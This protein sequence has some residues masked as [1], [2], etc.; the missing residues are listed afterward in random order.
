MIEYPQL[1]FEITDNAMAVLNER[2]LLRDDEGEIVEEPQDIFK[3]VAEKIASKEK[4]AALRKKWAK[5]YYDIMASGFFMPNS[6]TLMNAGKENNS[7]YSGC[8]VFPVE[9]KI[10]GGKDSIFGCIEV[11]GEI[12]KMGGGTGCSFA[13]IRGR[14]T[15]VN[16]TGHKAS[17]PVSFMGNYNEAIESIQQGGMRRGAHMSVLP[18]NHVDIKEFINSKSSLGV[19]MRRISDRVVKE[20]HLD[21]DGEFIT[22][23]ERALINVQLTNMNNSVAVTKEFKEALENKGLYKLYDPKYGQA[24]IVKAEEIFDMIAQNAW[25][26]GEPGIIDLERI[27]ENNPVAHLGKI[28]TT[29]PCGEVPLLPWE[30]CNLGSIAISRLLMFR[31]GHW[32]VNYRKLNEIINTAVRFLDSVIDTQSYPLKEI[33][34]AT[35]RTRK[36]GLG[37]MGLADALIKLQI[38][39]GSEECINFI[40][41][42]MGTYD[43]CA[44]K[45]SIKLAKEKGNFPGYKGSQYEK[46]GI[47]MR[48]ATRLTVAP[49]GSIAGIAG[50]SFGIEPIFAAIYERT[51]LDGKKFI[52]VA[53]PVREMLEER[54]EWYDRTA[55]DLFEGKRKLPQDLK[56]LIITAHDVTPTQHVEMQAAF[57][58]HVDNAV[59]KTVNLPSTATVDDIK[60]IFKLAF[61]L[62]CKGITVYRDGSRGGQVLSTK[63]TG[64]KSL[65][66]VRNRPRILTGKTY[67]RNIGDCGKLFVT[68]N[69]DKNGYPFEI[70][71]EAGKAGGCLSSQMQAIGRL[72]SLAW[73]CNLGIEGI[74]KQLRGITC[75]KAKPSLDKK[76]T[77]LSCSDAVVRVIEECFLDKI[78][79][80][81]PEQGQREAVCPDCGGPMK[82]EG[83]CGT[84]LSCIKSKCN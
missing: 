75:H 50:V 46:D 7:V 13:H 43:K 28:E 49:T 33:E 40:D 18:I 81:I 79:E 69:T 11:M 54:G 80:E 29:N 78:E 24:E 2:Y 55:E 58:R 45:A 14:N 44:K 23:I 35:K 1:G 63:R 59:S 38:V 67:E 21:E 6:P 37:I 30:S 64:R 32:S 31:N 57:Q 17:G 5:K 76:G 56:D 83:R 42:L 65:R 51:I 20:L 60:E 39:Y 82:Y 77:F 72:I 71:V 8:F 36:I 70:F 52:E 15:Q 26:S 25:G 12:H 48:N 22:T 47:P 68:I 84:C 73:R 3:R 41:S 9:D 61:K 16:S 19:Q 74:I 27:N 62:G 10:A 53:T 34:K 4:N 66:K